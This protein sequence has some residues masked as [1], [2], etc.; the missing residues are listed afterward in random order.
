MLST[1]NENYTC[2]LHCQ[3][4]MPGY[5]LYEK[6]ADLAVLNLYETTAILASHTDRLRSLLRKSRF[7]D[8]NSAIDFISD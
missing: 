6:D 7:I 4:A 8:M 3:Q 1:L 5:P 2:A